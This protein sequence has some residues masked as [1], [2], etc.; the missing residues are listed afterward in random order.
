MSRKKRGKEAARHGPRSNLL[1]LFGLRRIP[2][3]TTMRRRLD[4]VCT[5]YFEG[6]F[7]AL[8]QWVDQVQLW[9]EFYTVQGYVF[10]VLDGTGVFSSQKI[11]CSHC[12]RAQHRDGSV[13]YSH[14]LVTAVMI[15]PQG[16]ASLPLGAEPIGCAD[17]A[18]K[19]DCEQAA[20]KRL[21]RRLRKRYPNLRMVILAD[22]LYSTGPM[23]KLF[24]ELD[25]D[26][27]VAVKSRQHQRG[28]Y[29]YD[30]RHGL[31][32]SKWRCATKFEASQERLPKDRGTL[33]YRCLPARALN[34]QH[35]GLLVTVLQGERQSQKGGRKVVGEWVT[36]LP[37][38]I[39]NIR[40]FVRYA[41]R[42]WLIENCVFK[43][44]KAL[45][46]MNFEHNYAHGKNALCDNLAQLMVIAASLDQLCLLR[47]L[48]FQQFRQFATSWATMWKFQR[49]YLSVAAV[50]DWRDFYR[51]IL[52]GKDPPNTTS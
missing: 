42:R 32:E 9:S 20:A 21:L 10:V 27:L 8:F 52:G 50:T 4:E 44:M 48:Y 46:G 13:T 14:Q 11:H 6:I 43:T 49:V 12:R 19:N 5:S 33:I 22:A 29:T 24:Q 18:Q 39:D 7:R 25:M 1:R 28:V 2:S 34:G 38:D 16:T 45:T 17:G 3:D 30:A 40:L 36:S 15:H 47:C 26:Y 51:L 31:L 35:P 37:V 23:I 41:R